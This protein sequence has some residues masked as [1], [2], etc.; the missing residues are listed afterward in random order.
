MYGGDAPPGPS[1]VYGREEGRIEGDGNGVETTGDAAYY[2]VTSGGEYA[3]HYTTPNG[4][5]VSE[6]ELKRSEENESSIQESL[7]RAVVNPDGSIQEQPQ[8]H[9]FIHFRCFAIV[10]EIGDTDQAYR[11]RCSWVHLHTLFLQI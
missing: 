8:V 1:I 11:D 2:Q 6:E 3:H 10:L 5:Y 7:A 9:L 4:Q